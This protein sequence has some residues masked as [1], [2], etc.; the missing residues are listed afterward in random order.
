MKQYEMILLLKKR[1]ENDI[2]TKAYDIFVNVPNTIGTVIKK[3]VMKRGVTG[4][5][6]PFFL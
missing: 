2:K 1:S 3:H 5:I 6:S 4:I